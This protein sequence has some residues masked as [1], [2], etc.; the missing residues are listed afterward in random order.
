MAIDQV[1]ATQGAGEAI[2]KGFAKVN[3]AITALNT[4]VTKLDGIEAGATADQIASEIVVLLESLSGAA[5]LDADAIEVVSEA[6]KNVE[7]LFDGGYDVPI[8]PSDVITKSPWV[9]V[10]AYASIN[11]AITAIGASEDTL[12]IPDTQTLTSAL[13]VPSNVTIIFLHNGKITLGDYNLTINGFIQ[14]LPKQIFN[15]SG[16]GTVTIGRLVEKIYPDWWTVNATP[17]TTD[18]TSAIESAC[19][20]I[21]AGPAADESGGTV[22]LLPTSYGIIDLTIDEAGIILEGAGRALKAAGATDSSATYLVALAGATRSVYVTGQ[23][24][25]IKDLGINGDSIAEKFEI[26]GS[27]WRVDNII[28][29]GHTAYNFFREVLGG[30]VHGIYNSTFIGKPVQIKSN[31]VNLRNNVFNGNGTEV[32]LR[33]E[34]AVVNVVGN[35]FES[36]ADYAIEVAYSY[37]SKSVNILNNYFETAYATTATILVGGAFNCTN[38]VLIGNYDKYDVAVT[39]SLSIKHAKDA[40]IIGN[41]WGNGLTT[42]YALN[43]SLTGLIL[44]GNAAKFLI[45]SENLIRNG[46]FNWWAKGTSDVPPFWVHVSGEAVSQDTGPGKSGYSITWTADALTDGI[47]Q[48]CFNVKPNT[49]YVLGFKCKTASGGAARIRLQGDDGFTDQNYNQGSAGW[50]T[51]YYAIKTKAAQTYIRIRP[52]SA[53]NEQTWW[54]DIQLRE[55]NLPFLHQVNAKDEAV[56]TAMTA[57]LD[58]SGAAAT[59]IAI[60]SENGVKITKAVF[61]YTEASSA[62]AG[63]NL[64][65]GKETDDDYYLAA[66]A[67]EINKALWYSKTLTLL[68]DDIATGDT[69]IFSSAGS[70]SGTG[71]VMLVLEY[72]MN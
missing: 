29:Y 18:M 25:T 62:D 40:I 70:K 6:G 36:Y 4:A 61:L 12:L 45:S 9:D 68:K 1:D 16:T 5:K 31:T 7:D 66:E 54:A 51:Y 8:R 47:S 17:G 39:T 49:N 63:I 15:C 48:Y 32:C 64:K 67:S 46:N 2:Y 58:L 38:P 65:I 30:S 55:G 57:S 52:Q 69:V 44:D 50:T 60:H 13:V 33:T 23:Y 11:A 56:H 22:K 14:A 34:G 35:V 19:A 37:S 59:S 28:S 20:S 3:Q 71:E 27:Y 26:I 24:V 41:Y 53:L 72:V 10:R 42:T 43:Q 21:D